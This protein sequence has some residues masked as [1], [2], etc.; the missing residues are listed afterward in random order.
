MTWNHRVIR[1]VCKAYRESA[2]PEVR[3]EM[4]EVF[5]EEGVAWGHGRVNLHAETLEEMKET[6]ARLQKAC[7]KTTLDCKCDET[8]ERDEPAEG[9]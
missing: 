8:K 5:Y 4:Q 6:V 3:L 9:N 7:E 2:E 1:H